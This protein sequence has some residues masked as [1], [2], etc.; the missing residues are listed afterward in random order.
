MKKVAFAFVLTVIALTVISQIT[1]NRVLKSGE[2]GGNTIIYELK[3]GDMTLAI[4]IHHGEWTPPADKL[5]RSGDDGKIST[6]NIAVGV[7]YSQDPVKGS[8]YR[9][10]LPYK[11]SKDT[12]WVVLPA[13]IKKALKQAAA[14]FTGNIENPARI[15]IWLDPKIK[16]NLSTKY[17]HTDQGWNYSTMIS[18]SSVATGYTYFPGVQHKAT[19]FVSKECEKM[20]AQNNF[21]SKFAAWGEDKSPQKP[22]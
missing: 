6:D 16:G 17:P 10:F 21:V 7:Y 11:F 19:T 15:E 1:Y 5:A 4:P 20:F 12:L 2:K 22:F 14:N 3:P 13:D 8:S 18:L 9:H